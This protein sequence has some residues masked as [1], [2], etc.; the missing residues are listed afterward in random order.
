MSDSPSL[1][2]CRADDVV[3]PKPVSA[4]VCG[5]ERFTRRNNINSLR[6]LGSICRCSRQHTSTDPFRCITPETTGRPWEITGRPPGR[7]QH[8]LPLLTGIRSTADMPPC[9]CWRPTR[10][11]P[12]LLAAL[13]ILRAKVRVFPR[14]A[15]DRSTAQNVA[16]NFGSSDK[17]GQCNGTSFPGAGLPPPKISLH[18]SRLHSCKQTGCTVLRAVSV[19]TTECERNRCQIRSLG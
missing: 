16:I 17:C 10:L 9:I 4:Q 6:Q 15:Q 14:L 18:G 1:C 13:R 2:R 5:R 7:G 11:S 12:H 19:R 3:S 8:F